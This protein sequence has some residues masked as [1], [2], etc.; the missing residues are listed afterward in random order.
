MHHGIFFINVNLPSNCNMYINIY[1]CT[2]DL[3]IFHGAHIHW[4]DTVVHALQLTVFTQREAHIVAPLF[5]LLPNVL[6]SSGKIIGPLRLYSERLSFLYRSLSLDY[7]YWTKHWK[8]FKVHRLTDQSNS[9]RKS[10]LYCT[11][12]NLTTTCCKT[13]ERK[14]LKH[15]WL[16]QW[17]KSD[18]LKRVKSFFFF[19]VSFNSCQCLQQELFLCF[20]GA[21]FSFIL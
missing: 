21:Y 14:S 9:R 15:F 1:T 8:R 18:E 16:L 19:F 13:T 3:K 12:V 7:S 20:Y 10:G 6:T 2:K 11:T 17:W 4:H 5:C